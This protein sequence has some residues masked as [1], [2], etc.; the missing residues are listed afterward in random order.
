MSNRPT[1]EDAPA[2]QP[3]P[4]PSFEEAVDALVN[5]ALRAGEWG[6]ETDGLREVE[7]ARAALL[8]A[9]REALAEAWDDGWLHPMDTDDP[10]FTGNPHRKTQEKP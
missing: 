2:P 4:S 7:T 9:H 8:A 10:T 6:S 1:R 5:T 3:A